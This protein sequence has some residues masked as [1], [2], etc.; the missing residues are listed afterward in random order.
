MS[1]EPRDDDPDFLDDFILDDAQE[2]ELDRL[3]DDPG[4]NG[5]RPAGAGAGE[6]EGAAAGEEDVLFEDHTKAAA[7]ASESFG[8][9]PPFSESGTSN[10]KGEEL[11]LEEHGVPADDESGAATPAAKQK[12]G[13]AKEA[14]TEQLDSL[15]HSE[16][17]EEDFGLDSE[18]ELELVDAPDA[19]PEDAEAGDDAGDEAFVV[20]DAEDAAEAAPVGATGDDADEGAIEGLEVSE[21]A[22]AAEPGWEPLPQAN[23]DNLAEAEVVAAEDGAGDGYEEAA[24]AEQPAPEPALVGADVEGHDL[25]AEEAPAAPAQGVIGRSRRG[26][27]VLRLLGSLAASVAVLGAA[28]TVVLRPEWFGLRFEP[29]RIQRVELKRPKVELDVPQPPVVTLPEPEPQPVPAKDPEPTTPKDPEPRDPP[30][31]GDPTEPAPRVGAA[32]PVPTTPKD[33]VPGAEPAPA[34]PGTSPVAA[35]PVTDPGMGWP[36]QT[37]DNPMPAPGLAA[38]LVRV[39]D[40]LMVGDMSRSAQ[41]PSVAIEGMLPGGRAFAQLHNGNYFIGAVKSVDARA[42]T[43][44]I[45][46]GEITLDTGSIAKL[47]ALGSA[48]YEELQKVTS[49]FIRLTNNNRLVGSILSGIADDHVILEVRSNR[50]MLPKSAIGEVVEGAN[51]SNVRIDTTREEDDWLRQMAERQLDGT[52]GGK[53]TAPPPPSPSTPAKPVPAPATPPAAPRGG[54]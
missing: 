42:I 3:F 46:T 23:V 36:I 47:T 7:D 48:E 20:D 33:P 37:G 44:R 21:E 22:E 39:N 26:G 38:H 32:D 8:G 45:G 13:K 4:A 51:E 11:E 24:T 29:D 19:M 41:R 16:Q 49:G 15:L 28:A 50:V 31:A 34:N 52:D 43:L 9:G 14:F 10:W 30:P 53:P 2:R 27:R 18:R 35:V 1:G 54:R 17:S 5:K 40:D 6:A 25:Y 12:L